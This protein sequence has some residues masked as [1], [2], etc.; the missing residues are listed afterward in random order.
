MSKKERTQYVVGYGK[1]PVHSRFQKGQSGNRKGR[2]KNS[3]S[4]VALVAE[5]LE[6]RVSVQEGGRRRS[7]TKR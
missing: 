5:A 2:P 6:E 3:K 4:F 7:L 1:P